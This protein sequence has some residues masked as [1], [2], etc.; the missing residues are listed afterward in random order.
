MPTEVEQMEAEANR[1]AAAL[2]M[3][4]DRCRTLALRYAEQ[5]GGKRAVLARRLCT[6]FLVSQAAMLRRLTDLGLIEGDEVGS[7]FP[8]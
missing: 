2:L 6:E 7:G 3:P 1:F 8:A 5:Y 4:A